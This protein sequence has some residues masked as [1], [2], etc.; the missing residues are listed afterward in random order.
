M[1]SSEERAD[2]SVLIMSSV[3]A[4]AVALGLLGGLAFL[5][6]CVGSFTPNGS[7]AW[8]IL[9]LP[10]LAALGTLR[11]LGGRPGPGADRRPD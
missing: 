7:L 5:A 10:V 9:A 2:Q 1:R 4:F 11:W 6:S 3:F 8:V